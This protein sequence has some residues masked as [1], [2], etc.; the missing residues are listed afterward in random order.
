MVIEELREILKL[1]DI[2]AIHHRAVPTDYEQGYYAG[3][4]VAK[5]LIINL[6]RIRILGLD[7]DN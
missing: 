6:D 7:N 3:L 2:M 5:R 1:L 4:Q